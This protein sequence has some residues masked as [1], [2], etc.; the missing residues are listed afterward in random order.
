MWYTLFSMILYFNIKNLYLFIWLILYLTFLN[1]RHF[2][3]LAALITSWIQTITILHA[4][5]VFT[6]LIMTQ[7]RFG[8][9]SIYYKDSIMQDSSTIYEPISVYCFFF[10]KNILHSRR[11]RQS[12]NL[13]AFFWS[14]Y[15]YYLLS[16]LKWVW[17][18][19]H[20]AYNRNFVGNEFKKTE[21]NLGII[22]PN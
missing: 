17:L 20:N 15:F 5:S 10:W 8:L 12:I 14:E 11:P 19:G 4:V 22:R 18:W 3:R 9:L 21:I 2:I 16:R 6:S 13:K 1:S 7:N